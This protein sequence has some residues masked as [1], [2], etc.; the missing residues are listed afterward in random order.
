MTDN[1]ILIQIPKDW[2]E[3]IQQSEKDDEIDAVTNEIISLAS[4]KLKLKKP[5]QDEV[6]IQFAKILDTSIIEVRN[7]LRGVISLRVTT[8]LFVRHYGDLFPKDEKGYPILKPNE[9]AWIH[10]RTEKEVIDAI[11]IHEKELV[12]EGL[13][14]DWPD[15]RNNLLH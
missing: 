9:I 12:D 15:V 10:G 4:K 2:L 5:S 1:D 13:L 7:L 8:R 11:Y 3:Q 14:H 6:T